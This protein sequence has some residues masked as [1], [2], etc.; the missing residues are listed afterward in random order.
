MAD[1]NI[2][3]V[4]T[5]RDEASSVLGG[6]S[7]ALGEATKGSAILLGG[8]AALGIGAYKSVQAFQESQNIAAQL[9]NVLRSTGGAAGVTSEEAIKLSKSLEHLTGISDETAL[10]AENVLLT[11]TSIHKDAFPEATKAAVDMAT[12]LNHGMVPSM[13][14]VQAKAMLIGKALQDPD[15]GLGALHRVGVNVEELKKKFTDSMSVQEKQKLILQELGTEFGGAGEAAGKTFAGQI[16]KLNET[17]NDLMENIGGAIVGFINPF[18]QKLSDW[19]DK[20]GG[21]DG[22]TKTM[23]ETF[24]KFKQYLPEII[25]GILGSLI[26]AFVALGASIWS[27][28]APLLPF[29]AAG[30]LLGLIVK[31]VIDHFGG[32]D[33]T[34]KAMQPIID[35]FKKAWERIVE[36]WNT[37]L[38]PALQLLWTMFTTQLLPVLK[39]FWE[40]NKD[41]IIPALEGLAIIIG[42]VVLVAI[43]GLIGAAYVVVAVL[44]AVVGAINWVQNAFNSSAQTVANW[45]KNVSAWVHNVTIGIL[46]AFGNLGN[47]LNNWALNTINNIVGFFQQ[48]PGR[49]AGAVGQAGNAVGHALHI[50]GFASGVTNFSGGLALVGEQGP[51]VVALP[52]GSSVIPNNQIGSVG[53]GGGTINITVQAGAFMGSQQDARKYAMQILDSLKDVAASKGTTVGGLF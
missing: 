9:D 46:N 8:L 22:I 2:R 42:G 5:A 41:K 3:A 47:N 49:I 32:W 20:M 17:L 39:Q 23:N 40:Q 30:A 12:A 15:A 21:V 38:L 19:V 1:A 36:V 48:L 31:A 37:V 10:N 7:N 34:L 11:F 35:W 18:I 4:I 51:E 45:S 13:E 53:G 24:G 43:L 6:F 14:D 25:G 29:I 26:P 27:A 28:M 50:P 44:T 33:N 52:R 16:A